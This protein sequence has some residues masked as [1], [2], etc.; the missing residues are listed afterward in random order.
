MPEDLALARRG[1]LDVLDLPRP[2]VRRQV[3]LGAVLHPLDRDLQPARQRQRE[4]LLRVHV[5]LGAETP[6]HVRR[7]DPQLGIR[8][9][10]DQARACP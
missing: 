6:A 4:R 2:W 10:A 7:H 9:A 3:V 1:E 5:Q 8:D